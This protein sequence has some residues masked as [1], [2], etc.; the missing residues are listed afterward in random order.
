VTGSATQNLSTAATS[1]YQTA[2]C[3]LCADEMFICKGDLGFVVLYR[4]Y[5]ILLCDSCV[6]LCIGDLLHI[7]RFCDMQVR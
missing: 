1:K 2:H 6:N 3:C 7:L 5:G 4:V